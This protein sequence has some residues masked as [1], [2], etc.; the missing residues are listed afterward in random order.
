[1]YKVSPFVISS[2][3]II[4]VRLMMMM[5]G[6][7]LTPAGYFV[8]NTDQ[9]KMEVSLADVAITVDTSFDGTEHFDLLNDVDHQI[10]VV[11]KMMM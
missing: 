2:K 10:V 6:Y 8:I 11:L 3:N 4:P 1:M 5:L 9:H 7:L